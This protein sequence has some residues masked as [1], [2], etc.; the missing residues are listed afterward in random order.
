MRQVYQLNHEGAWEDQ[1]TGYAAIVNRYI[2]VYAEEVNQRSTPSNARLKSYVPQEE[3][4]STSVVIL[5][6]PVVGDDVYQR[7]GGS[8]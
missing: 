3:K 7:Q 2:V 8:I 6:A 4:P 1:G 5:E